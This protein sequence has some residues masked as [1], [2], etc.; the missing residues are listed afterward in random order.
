MYKCFTSVFKFM[1]KFLKVDHFLLCKIFRA[2]K[3]NISIK[4][5]FININNSYLQEMEQCRAT[6]NSSQ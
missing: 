3:L 5:L 1:F 6:L 2:M 4:Y